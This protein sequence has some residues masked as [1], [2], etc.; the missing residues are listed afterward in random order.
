M[1]LLYCNEKDVTVIHYWFW[2][3]LST[4]SLCDRWHHWLYFHYIVWLCY[5]DY[6]F[7]TQSLRCC[8][9]S[10][11]FP[12]DVDVAGCRYSRGR[13]A[14]VLLSSKC[15]PLTVM[16]GHKSFWPHII[17]RSNCRSRS[18]RNVENPKHLG[19]LSIFSQ[20]YCFSC[21]IWWGVW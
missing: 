17:F 19:S 20:C 15:S 18:R 3:I 2:L 1:H 11:N 16:R 5:S 7:Y 13:T 4:Q 12:T 21:Q 14:A 9:C 8:W 6:L 10:W